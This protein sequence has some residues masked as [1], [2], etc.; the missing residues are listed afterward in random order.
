MFIKTDTMKASEKK[1]LQW[2]WDAIERRRTWSEVAN[3]LGSS[4]QGARMR[5]CALLRKEYKE[6][7]QYDE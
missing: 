5:F 1:E 2:C 3:K 6:R 4:E 7:H